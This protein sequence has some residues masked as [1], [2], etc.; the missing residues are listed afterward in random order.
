MLD[1]GDY[2]KINNFKDLIHRHTFLDKEYS[3][4]RHRTTF[5]LEQIFGFKHVLF[6][7]LNSVNRKEIWY[8]VHIHNVDLEFTQNFLSSNLMKERA[9]LGADSDVFVFS[10]M[11]N[12]K[13]KTVYMDLMQKQKYSDFLLFFLRVNDVYAGYLIIFKY[14]QQKNFVAQEVEVI[15][16]I[17]D[18][19]AVEYYNYSAY[20]NLIASNNLLLSHANYYPIGIV[21][22]KDLKEVVYTNETAIEY[23]QEL[24]I[25]EPKYFFLFFANYI[26]PIIKYEIRNLGKKRILRY[27]NF[28]FSIIAL[29]SS[30]NLEFMN[31]R[32]PTNL[33]EAHV[34]NTLPNIFNYIYFLK[35]ELSSMNA[36]QYSFDEFAF[37]KKELEIIERLL[38]GKSN[39]QI[40]EEMGISIN[41]VR[42]HINNIYKKCD[43]NN[44]T[45]FL[46]KI[47]NSNK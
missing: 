46:F 18:F 8:E 19:L 26:L 21:V 45:E 36:G 20:L 4:F 9:I 34:F 14:G 12:Y 38:R 39:K 24:G 42:V 2:I 31:T 28:I 17:K 7:Y 1:I 10:G 29:N 47:N 22:M 16:K 40:A 44:R 41:T 13:R 27:K 37:S 15:E 25:K 3:G 32:L 23:M 6:G 30:P 5:A 35:D 33:D 11:P 43:V